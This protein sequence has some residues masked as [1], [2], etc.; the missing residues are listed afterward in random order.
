MKIKIWDIPTRVFHWLLVVAYGIAFFSSRSE[1]LL[2]YHVA[3]G[4]I[5]L[6]LIIFRILWGFAGNSYARF[7]TFIKKPAVFTD[8][9]VQTLRLQPKRFLGHNP[10]SGWMILV[11]IILTIIITIS[12][13]LVFSGE[14]MSGIFAGIVS[15]E[16]AMVARSIHIFLS[17]LAILMI[18]AHVLAVLFHEFY[19]NENIIIPMFTGDKEDEKSYDERVSHLHTGD[20]L[21][22]LKLITYI[23]I[24]LLGGI[25]LF[26]LPPKGKTDIS[27]LEQPKV[28]DPSGIIVTIP[29]SDAWKEE[30]A[31]S[32]HRGFH[33]NLMPSSSWKKIMA[34]LDDHFGESAELDNNAADEILQY[35]VSASAEK[36]TTEAGKKM[37]YSIKKQETPMRITEIPYW[38]KKHSEIPE[39]IFKRKSISNKNNCVACHPGAE[40]GSFEDKD[41]T[42]PKK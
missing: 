40:L 27:R 8:Y 9:L 13:I 21:P 2:E 22:P 37:L 14:E 25:A 35:L 38:E 19:L 17:Y 36:A 32:C 39:A 33:P 5:A 3:A 41:I 10:A 11:K 1:W 20:V 28:F 16:T 31:E 26:F 4:Y 6:G 7:S 42:I 23:I 15:F 34:G 30:C 18:V 12:G 29:V 24:T